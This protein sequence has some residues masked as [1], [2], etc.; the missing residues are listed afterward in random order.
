ML[1]KG[2]ILSVFLYLCPVDFVLLL[3]VLDLTKKNRSFE[4]IFVVES[5]C[6]FNFKFNTGL[7]YG[8][9]SNSFI[10]I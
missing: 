6:F 7:F 3:G 8:F 2:M 9:V 4:C 10:C 1:S 5:I